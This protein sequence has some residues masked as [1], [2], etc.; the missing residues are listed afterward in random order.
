M[1][2][3]VPPYLGPATF[4]PH[5]SSRSMVVIE[6]LGAVCFAWGCDPPNAIGLFNPNCS[7]TLTGW[8]PPLALKLFW[9]DWALMKIAP[10]C[11]RDLYCLSCWV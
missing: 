3:K 8:L 2:S 5:F 6:V 9:K 7:K 1:W 4:L 11:G 10:V